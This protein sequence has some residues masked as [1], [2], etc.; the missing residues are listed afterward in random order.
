MLNSNCAIQHG[1]YKVTSYDFTIRAATVSWHSSISTLQIAAIVSTILFQLFDRFPTVPVSLLLCV[2][3]DIVFLLL[4]LHFAIGVLEES[5]LDVVASEL[6]AVS[7]KWYTLGEHIGLQDNEL[8]PIHTQYSHHEKLCLKKVIRMRMGYYSGLTWS[9][10]IAGLRS[11]GDSQLAD[12]L[13]T[14]YC[15]S[16]LTTTCTT[17]LQ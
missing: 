6:D 15:S 1:D 2:H 10:T 4:Y 17:A 11:S 8:N 9:D 5:D 16:E 3:M 12:H 7:S 13:E 14:K